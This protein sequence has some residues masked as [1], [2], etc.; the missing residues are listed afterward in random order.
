ML[1]ISNFK[2]FSQNA[3]SDVRNPDFIMIKGVKF[4]IRAK[5]LNENNISYL[6]LFINCYET[7]LK[8]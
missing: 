3:S 8:R 2:K 4:K 1:K 7:P 5:I 6:S